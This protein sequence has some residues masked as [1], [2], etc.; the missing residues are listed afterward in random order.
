MCSRGVDRLVFSSSCAVYG[1]PD[2][3]PIRED[4][5]IRPL[6]PY[7]RT[8]AAVEGI[9]ADYAAA[10]GLRYA[11]L[12]YFNAA[13]AHPDG[14]LGEDHDPETHLIP[15]VILAALGKRRGVT[16]F[17]TDYPTPDGT[18]LRDY[19]QVV[20]LAAAH[21][22][23]LEALQEHPA[24]T[25][26][27]STERGHSVREVI[28]VVRRVSGRD[29]KVACA[30]RRQGDPPSLVGS[31]RKIEQELGWKPRYASIEQI[32]ETAWRWHSTH[33][34]GFRGR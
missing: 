19:V 21:V 27:L 20:D 22:M 26:N 14:T 32:V 23:A 12:R 24:M 5:P 6:S 17:G 9:L 13:G 3:L 16:V 25:Y 7:G 18:C 33:P 28:E 8:K 30:P 15:L 1:V 31:S 4:T 10:Y 29:V 34:G 11:S 2:E